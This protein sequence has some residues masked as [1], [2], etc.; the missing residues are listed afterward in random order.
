M[1]IYAISDL[2]LSFCSDPDTVRWDVP[3]HKPMWEI[4]RGWEDHARRIYENWTGA[5]SREDLVLLPGD[6]SWAMRLEE[7][8]PDIHYLSLLPGN[9]VAVQGNHDYWWQSVSRARKKMPPNVRL[10][11]NDCVFFEGLAVCGTRGWL[12]PNGA[13][14][15]EKDMKIYQRE[16]IRLEMSLKQA[17]GKA[18]R[19]IAMMHY[20]PTNEKNE[21]SGFIDLFQRYGVDTVVY[22]HLHS[23]ACRYRLPDKCW[24]I[25]FHLVSADFLGFSPAHI[26]FWHG[27]HNI[28]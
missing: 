7:A 27:A 18:E 11:Q 12:C 13:F 4:D 23:R 20:M 25:N 15:G 21:H 6:I 1:N 22:G 28:F 26:G 10:I 14:F 2:H 8:G 16:L 5:I 17:G 24:G 9:I 3:E 19:I